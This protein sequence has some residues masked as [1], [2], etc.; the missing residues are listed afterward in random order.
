[1]KWECFV[2]GFCLSFLPFLF[3]NGAIVFLSPMVI[4]AHPS[5]FLL[6]VVISAPF[7]FAV[8]GSAKVA[9]ECLSGWAA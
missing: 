3:P 4:F 6:G 8:I 2:G 5:I 9:D 7:I 1:M